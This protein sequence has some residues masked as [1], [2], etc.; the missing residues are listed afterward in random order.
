VTAGPYRWPAVVTA[1]HDGDTITAD[2]NLRGFGVWVRGQVFR[3][4]GCNARELAEPGGLEARDHL[5]EL[6]NFGENSVTLTSIRPDKFGG[7]YDCAITL[8]DGSDLVAELI[9]DGWAAAWDGRGIKPVPSW[10][11]P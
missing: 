3:L 7:R 1:V 4:A 2:V 5:R 10:P 8:P 6:L 11:R 9:A